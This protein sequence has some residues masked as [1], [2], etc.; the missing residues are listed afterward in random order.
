[1]TTI[2]VTGANRGLGLEFVKQYLAEGCDVIAFCRN[3][4]TA[5]DLCALSNGKLDIHGVDVT[6]FATIDAAKEE[7]SD[8]PIDILINNAGVFG[9]KPQADNDFRQLMGHLDY[10]MWDNIMKINALG[11]VRIVECFL[12]NV[13]ASDQKKII[14]ISAILGSIGGTA[15]GLY[16]YRTSKAAVNM[17]MA[18]LAKE[19]ADRDGKVLMLNPGWVKTDMGGDDAPFTPAQS[20][21]NLRKLINQLNSNNSGSFLEHDGTTIRW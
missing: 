12:E 1:M 2:L 14:S 16:P 11:P 9:P 13:L 21:E 20:I 17:A 8:R 18:T 6:D 10:D 15:G 5:L 7:I 4:A 3:P 19:V